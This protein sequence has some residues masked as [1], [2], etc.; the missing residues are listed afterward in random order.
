MN[1]KYLIG[2]DLGTSNTAV[3]Y[4]KL[5]GIDEKPEFKVFEIP[6][7]IRPGEILSRP[8]LPSFIY[9]P[10]DNEKN[11]DNFTLDWTKDETFI[12]GEYAR[13]RSSEIPSRVISSAKSWLCN[14][15]VNREDKILPWD[16][17]QVEEK[18]SPVRAQTEILNH[19]K[20]AWDY[21]FSDEEESS[22]VEQNI[23]ITI[24]ASFDAVARE[25][26][27]K[28]SRECGIKN[29]TLM[30]EP[31]AAFY[32]WLLLNEET[33][34]K[35]VK[36]DESVL[37]CDIGGGTSDFTLIKIFETDGNLELERTAVGNHLL[38][39]GDNMDLSIS[40]LLNSKIVSSGKKLDKWQLRSLVNKAREAKEELFS[41]RTKEK[42]EIAVHSRGMKL[43]AGTIKSEILSKEL[44]QIVK[45]GFFPNCEL[46]EKP[47]N[48]RKTGLMEAG[49]NY[50]SDPAITKHLAEF[51][52]NF[53]SASFP[54]YVLFNGGVMKSKDLRDHISKVLSSWNDSSEIKELENNNSEISVALGA[55]Y[56]SFIKLSGGIRIKSGLNK[57]YYIEVSS[58]MPAIP[59]IPVPTKAL[60][61]A[62][63]GM[64]E[65]SFV[66]IEDK[67]YMLT[68]GEDVSFNLFESSMG[69]EDKPGETIEDFQNN[70][71][72]L[73]EIETFLEGNQGDM[74]PVVLETHV[75]EI[76]T[77]EFYCVSLEDD[78]KWKLEFNLR[79]QNN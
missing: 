22:F 44:D 18:F 49:L 65:G 64:E 46:E 70:L 36:K 11:R 13:K 42:Y 17:D 14:N 55:A 28:A 43:I 2:I 50:E 23:T 25:L 76:G 38:V 3:S 9:F 29:L 67:K 5:T 51:T 63:F 79:Q 10:A 16:S 31:Q 56:Y 30:E 12:V 19:I 8:L 68:L 26:T 7:I 32:S 37:V 40:Y 78:R 57:T 71:E 41:D 27:L 54:A 47:V 6:Q 69:K 21:K 15:H 24:P 75:T 62:P 60:C 35:K 59:G 34:R 45:N 74:V 53:A 61:V 20:N 58:S 73:T 4:A 33:W 72:K 52:S 48:N 1:A 66:K 39:G 77:L